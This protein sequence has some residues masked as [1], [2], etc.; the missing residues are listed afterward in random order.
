MKNSNQVYFSSLLKHQFPELII[1]LENGLTEQK[2]SFRYLSNTKDIWCRDFMPIPVEKEQYLLFRYY[3]NYLKGVPEIRTDNKLVCSVNGISFKY[4][5]LIID[6]GNVVRFGSKAILTDRIFL[7]NNVSIGNVKLMSQLEKLLKAELII[8]PAEDDDVI[9]HADGMVR[10][11][12]ENTV[13]VNDYS[14]TKTPRNFQKRLFNSLEQ[15]Q[16]EIKLIPYFP[17]EKWKPKTKYDVAPATGVYI[18]YLQV[19]ESLFLPQFNNREQ[20]DMATEQFELFFKKVVKINCQ[21]LAMGGGLL[22]CVSWNA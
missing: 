14:K 9:G 6:G 22:N 17:N 12:S 10:F 4:S 5:S 11:I 21:E 1:E 13:L 16:L 20:D 15:A 18:N 19:G 7:D 2:I 3:P 8:I